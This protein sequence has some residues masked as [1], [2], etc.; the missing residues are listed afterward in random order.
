[1][2]AVGDNALPMI[3]NF[4]AV[5]SLGVVAGTSPWTSSSSRPQRSKAGAYTLLMLQMTLASEHTLISLTVFFVTVMYDRLHLPRS[6]SR[7][8]LRLNS[9]HKKWQTHLTAFNTLTTSLRRGALPFYPPIRRV[10]TPL[11]PFTLHRA[12]TTCTRQYRA[13]STLLHPPRWARSVVAIQL[14]WRA[15][16]K[17][18]ERAPAVHTATEIFR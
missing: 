2:L 16:T 5:D 6:L 15:L 4:P 12:E 1:M 3:T 8:Q 10:N 14:L 13:H 18:G 17:G 9:K 11:K 7:P